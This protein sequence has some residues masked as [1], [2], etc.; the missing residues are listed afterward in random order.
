MSG[1]PRTYTAEGI[2]LRRRNLGEADSIFTLFSDR[3][4]KFEGIAKG[5]RKARSRMGGHLEPLVRVRD[6][7]ARGRS[8]DVFTQA[9]V[10]DGYR[11]IRESLERTAAALSCAELVDRMTVEHGQQPGLFPL[12][13]AVF[14]GLDAGAP[15]HLV[16]YFELHLLALLGYEVQLQACAAC[17]GRLPPEETLLAPMAG[18]LVCHAC[19]G[20][21]GP[22]RLASVRA[23]K[24]LR[25]AHAAE[26]ADFAALRVDAPLATEL[27]ALLGELVRFHIERE[28][29]IGSSLTRSP[30]WP[31]SRADA[32]VTPLYN[33]AHSILR[34]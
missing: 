33:L 4:G 26:P 10:V 18:G 13:A 30:A 32:I 22:G 29:V 16:R 12:L 7:M 1:Q 19:R 34:D 3:E 27:Q 5:V 15:L 23:I 31:R 21:A 28:P 2:V 25:F 8:L 20:T 9:E 11:G 14:E 24:A 17:G 6:L